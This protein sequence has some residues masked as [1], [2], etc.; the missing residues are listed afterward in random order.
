MSLVIASVGAVVLLVIVQRVGLEMAWDVLTP[1]L[2]AVGLA[3]SLRRGVGWAL[4]MAV[5]LSA[6]MRVHPLVVFGVWAAV[7]LV[8]RAV[9]RG[10]EWE[11]PLV[12]FVIAALTSVG[13]QLGLL[14]LNWFGGLAPT[15]DR[16]SVLSIF[17]RSVTAG[18]GFM[19]SA[20]VLT[21]AADPTRVTRTPR[22]VGR[23]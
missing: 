14:L 7:I 10:V 5:V 17:A 6:A 23:R 12:M 9:A 19:L 11:Q 1:V 15:V 16:Y 8:L 21:R 13:W 3:G 20:G 4:I 18:L 22:G 2:V